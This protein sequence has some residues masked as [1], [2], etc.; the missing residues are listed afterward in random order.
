MSATCSLFLVQNPGA[1]SQIN[2][3][4]SVM[5]SFSHLLCLCCY[6]LLII[7][8]SMCFSAS[9]IFVL[10]CF[11]LLIISKVSEHVQSNTYSNTG[12]LADS[13]LPHLETASPGSLFLSY[14]LH[15]L[16]KT[17]GSLKLEEFFF[18]I[19]RSS[20]YLILRHA[21]SISYRNTCNR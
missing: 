11:E 18:L 3:S 15:F 7:S 13:K 20:L 6:S 17:S 4:S 9:D 8:S 12:F 16:L 2:T 21:N 5:F 10:R 14:L 19:C 1:C